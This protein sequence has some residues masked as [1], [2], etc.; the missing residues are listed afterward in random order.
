[1]FELVK[2]VLDAIVLRDSMKKG[3]MTAGVWGAALLFLFVLMLIAVP[4]ILYLDRHP[5]APG[6]V[7]IY[8]GVAVGLLM[9]VYFWLGIRWRLRLSRRAQGDSQS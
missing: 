7:L 8:P 2:L 5:D 9:I 3:E 6:S 4:T 1:M